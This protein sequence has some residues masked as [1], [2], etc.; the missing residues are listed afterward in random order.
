LNRPA[1]SEFVWGMIDEKKRRRRNKKF[2]RRKDSDFILY[3]TGVV[4]KN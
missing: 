4:M 1:I 3:E 2:R